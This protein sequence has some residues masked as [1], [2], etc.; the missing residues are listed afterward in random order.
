MDTFGYKSVSRHQH[1]RLCLFSVDQAVTT[2]VSVPQW[3]QQ[4]CMCPSLS[5]MGYRPPRC[6]EPSGSC[7]CSAP[8]TV[9]SSP[10]GR[11]SPPPAAGGRDAGTHRGK[12]RGNTDEERK[13]GGETGMMQRR[14]GQANEDLKSGREGG[15]LQVKHN[16]ERG[17]N[18]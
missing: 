11:Q 8:S 13:V 10:P 5:L 2:R 1:G 18:G 17:S 3:Q 9:R 12:E 16:I 15:K 6:S 7:C 14:G 4:S